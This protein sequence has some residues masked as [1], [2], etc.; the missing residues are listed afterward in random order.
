MPFIPLLGLAAVLADVLTS[1]LDTAVDY[2]E[3]QRTDAQDARMARWTE[4]AWDAFEEGTVCEFKVGD[5]Y[6]AAMPPTESEG[7]D[8][9]DEED[10]DEDEDE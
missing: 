8:W 3:H 1:V 4:R 9:E 7:D 6:L 2:K 10:L 5:V